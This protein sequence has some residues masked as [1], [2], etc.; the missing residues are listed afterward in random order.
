M[1]RHKLRDATVK[2]LSKAGKPGI[3]GDGDGLY[4]RIQKS[5]RGGW[6][7]IW[8]RHGARREIGLGAYAQ[9][10]LAAARAK[11]Q[12]ARAIIAS[13]GDPACE[14]A[15]RKSPKLIATFGTIADE[16]IETMKPKWRSGATLDHWKRFVA[17][18]TKPIGG[19]P[20]DKISTD[21][22]LRVLIPIWHSKPETAAKVRSRI[23]LMLDHAKAR[24]LRQGDNVAQWEAHL[25]QILP[26]PAK[27][28]NGH[29]SAM[30]YS[31]IAEFMQ[32]LRAG[33]GTGRMHSNSRF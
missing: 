11:A 28:V 5:G 15:E 10:S 12:E 18:Y 1:P 19:I 13:G 24:G 23:K 20:V 14:M 29:H 2:H 21:D 9:V 6:I 7:F 26:P 30:P 33:N 27:L 31:G 32:R 3:H 4:F 16:Y 17:V 8:R 25:N 22:V